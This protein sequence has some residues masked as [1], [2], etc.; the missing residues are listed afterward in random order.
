MTRAEQDNELW[1]QR[2]Y[3]DNNRSRACDQRGVRSVANDLVAVDGLVIM[4]RRHDRVL[5][6]GTRPV[7]LPPTDRRVVD[8]GRLLDVIQSSLASLVVGGEAPGVD[9]ASSTYRKV[10]VG[11]G[12]DERG[13]EIWN[14]YR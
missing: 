5:T 7:H 8:G 13:V 12:G 9:L 2:L 1:R 4:R 10:V 11:T 14:G 3:I 6:T